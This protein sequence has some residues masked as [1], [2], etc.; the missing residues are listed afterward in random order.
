MHRRKQTFT[1][2]T[3]QLISTVVFATRIVQFLFYL[4]K[5]VKFLACFVTVQVGLCRT[6]S[7]TRIV[8]FLMHR[9]SLNLSSNAN[10]IHTL[11]TFIIPKLKIKKEHCCCIAQTDALLVTNIKICRLKTL[12][13]HL[14]FEIERANIIITI[15]LI[16]FSSSKMHKHCRILTAPLMYLK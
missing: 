10:G 3:A 13:Q 8:G 6:W 12:L 5:D 9:L 16:Y 11:K 4:Y 1:F 15:L 2:T 14:D 7:G